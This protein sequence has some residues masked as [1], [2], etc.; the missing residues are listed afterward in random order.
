MMHATIADACM[1]E[2]KR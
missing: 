2:M 1:L